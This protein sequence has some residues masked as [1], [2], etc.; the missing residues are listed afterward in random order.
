M[1]QRKK[2]GRAHR[3]A[4]RGS[5]CRALSP[6]LRRPAGAGSCVAG[7]YMGRGRQHRRCTRTLLSERMRG[8]LYRKLPQTGAEGAGVPMLL[9]PLSAAR[10]Q[11]TPHLG[12]QRHLPG[13]LP[14]ADAG[15]NCGKAQKESP[16]LPSDGAGRGDHLYGRLHGHPYGKPAAGLRR[17]LPAPGRRRVCLSVGGGGG[18]CPHGCYRGGARRRPAILHGAAAVPVPAAG[19]AAAPLCPLPAA[20]GG[21]R[22]AAVQ[23][24]RR[25]EP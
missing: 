8:D 20:A 9:L 21:G 25:P 23:A 5:G 6:R 12:R 14:G 10:R 19:L 16:C 22:A 13:H 3:A 4:H 11:R 2:S 17:F 24:G 1:A 18:R 15:G 7:A